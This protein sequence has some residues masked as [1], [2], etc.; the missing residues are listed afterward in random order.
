MRLRTRYGH[1]LPLLWLMVIGTAA[2]D[3]SD[4]ER[5]DRIG[6]G[7]VERG[8]AKARAAGCLGCHGDE[9]DTG[10]VRLSAQPAAYLLA[11]LE[12]FA[13]GQRR[14]P[15]LSA[16][17]AALAPDDAADITA[18]FASREPVPAAGAIEDDGSNSARLFLHGD[19][20]RDVIACRSCH[21]DDGGG[22]VSGSDSYP[23]LAG[24]AADYLR[25]RLRS[26]RAGAPAG[27]P[28]SVMNLIARTLGDAEIDALSAWLSRQPRHFPGSPAPPFTTKESVR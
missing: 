5:A 16:E 23:A 19:R 4:E 6:V 17:A 24:Q 22:A 11:Q 3:W 26:W 18:W 27:A 10:H 20:S 15:Q 25:A 1:C 2:A 13:S 9:A 28:V 7:A 12:R 14:H 21:G 8:A